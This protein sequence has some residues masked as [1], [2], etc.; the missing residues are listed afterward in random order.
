VTARAPG[1]TDIRI[2]TLDE[3][4]NGPCECCGHMT[5]T[6][7][8]EA[9]VRGALRAV[10]YVRWTPERPDDKVGWLLFI[11]RWGKATQPSDRRGVALL[12]RSD[13]WWP[14]FMVIDPQETPWRHEEGK[15]GL[16]L[17]RHEVV[18]QPIA[19]EAFD[20]VDQVLVQDERV[21]ELLRAMIAAEV[22]RRPRSR[23]A[24]FKARWV[25]KRGGRREAG[26]T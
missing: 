5:R 15:L 22:P 17:R 6:V 20:I 25:A 18:G 24:R 21:T 4:L 13:R 16:F 2:V 1:P 3:S 23:W 26:G 10:Y 14:G 11:G 8:G 19:Q 7:W 12:M 9:H